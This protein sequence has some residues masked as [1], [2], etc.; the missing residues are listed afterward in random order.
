MKA[1]SNE[2]TGSCC[3]DNTSPGISTGITSLL[4]QRVL[5]F[6]KKCRRRYLD[7]LTHKSILTLDDKMLKDIGVPKGD[8][9]SVSNLSLS[10]NVMTELEIS[11]R[12]SN[13]TK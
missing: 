6:F 9:R 1:Q 11:A 3:A 5:E 4:L 7:K 8:I 2:L 13:H 10:T 12:R